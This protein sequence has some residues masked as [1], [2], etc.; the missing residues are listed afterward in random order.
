LAKK[1]YV[2][3]VLAAKDEASKAIEK[4]VRQTTKEFS[5]LNA[6]LRKLGVDSKEIG[7]INDEIKA[8]NPKILEDELDNVRNQLKRLGMDSKQIDKITKEMKEADKATEE[9][10]KSFESLRN[11]AK[12]AA[13]AIATAMAAATAGLVYATKGAADFEQALADVKA[14][15]GAT[16]SEMA[17]LQSLALEMGAK[18]KYSSVQ[19]AQGIEE[20]IKAGVSVENILKGGLKGA[21]SLAS[22]G[23]IE[24]ADAAEIAAT[25][26]NAFRDD[27]LTVPKAADILAGAANASATSVQE[28][29][30]SLAAVSA[31]A[32]GVGL[33]FNDTNVALAAFAQ[34]GLKGSDAGTSLKTML[35]NLQPQTKQQKE[36]FKELGLVTEQGTSAFFDANGKLKSMGEI[37]GLLQEK[38]KDMTDAQRL[39]AMEVLFGTDAIRAANILY[40]EGAEG[41]KK[42]KDEMSK[43]TAEQ[44]AAEK[45]NTVKGALL[46]FKSAVESITISIGT[47]F[48]GPIKEATKEVTA[49]IQSFNQKIQAEGIRSALQSLIPEKIAVQLSEINDLVT[50]LK[51]KI[52][53]Q[54]WKAV[55]Q[56]VGD[57]LGDALTGAA[58]FSLK[59]A[60]WVRQQIKQV[61]W[62]EVGKTAVEVAA[63]FILGFVTG[64]LDP[65]VWFNIITEHW[66]L[67][68]EIVIGIIAA[69]A[70][71]TYK[72]A[73]YLEKI[74]LVGTFV[75]WMMK[76][77]ADFGTW[78]KDKAV[79]VFKDFGGA[80]LDGLKQGVEWKGGNLLPTLRGVVMK[81][82]DGIK[83]TA[84]KMYEKGIEWMRSLGVSI[85]ESGPKQVLA[86]LRVIKEKIDV[87]LSIW[88]DDFIK[89]GKALVD[90]LWEGIQTKITFIK[91][92]IDEFSNMVSDGFKE[93]F[94]IRSPSKLM[95][96][97][98]QYIAEGL[99]VGIEAGTGK[100]KSAAEAM[101]KSVT[102][103][104]NYIKSV[105][106]QT[107][108]MT[109]EQAERQ[110]FTMQRLTSGQTIGTDADY[111]AYQAEIDRTA[112]EIS[113]RQGVDMG[114]ARD[115]AKTN[116]EQGKQVY[117]GISNEVTKLGP[118]EI[119]AI[120]EEGEIVVNPR[121][122]PKGESRAERAAVIVNL[123]FSFG[124]SVFSGSKHEFKRFVQDEVAPIVSR[125]IG[126]VALGHM[127][128]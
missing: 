87:G 43:V 84:S 89:Y 33:S 80:L 23:N 81:G 114:V 70:K 78:I 34:N 15:S 75:S 61:D 108:G 16:S 113:K 76:K 122:V 92:K 39:A 44:V 31:V 127:K 102:D 13:R 41:V 86:A 99:A 107:E 18:T 98:G 90:G 53:Q 103:S 74:P 123:S 37:A 24:L 4:S 93:F 11:T 26:L 83:D 126:R 67:I 9:T 100:V 88:V 128:V 58:D 1:N 52:E 94:G 72:L 3:I 124:T 14:V 119:P 17:K 63:G 5:S 55:G 45:M 22:A 27:A 36:L 101:S 116:I 118:K 106:A 57:A 6:S 97:Y 66:D 2:E 77:L 10:E 60:E 35:L 29:R 48:L 50:N 32:S 110:R 73:K 30:L 105:I 95:Q 112:I 96:E 115:M 104:A 8:A 91:G 46:E 85:G 38:L 51:A 20:L 59:L 121:K 82:I 71:W 56:M 117:H 47:P 25:A 40:K 125:E 64:I 109:M 21:L 12:I 62:G 7:K 69:P 28:L 111:A 65:T 79:E 54:D 49:F 19:A 120:L 42:M 68:L